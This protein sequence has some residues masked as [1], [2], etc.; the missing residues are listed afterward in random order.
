MDVRVLVTGALVMG[1]AGCAATATPAPPPTTVA[2]PAASNTVTATGSL[3]GVGRGGAVAVVLFSESD[4]ARMRTGQSVRLTVD[5]LPGVALRGTVTAIA[6]DAVNVSGVTEY[7]VTITVAGGD[8]RLR[9]GQTVQAT[10][11]VT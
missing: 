4:V 7:Y 8:S 1:L 3:S 2:H 10:V 5:A 11:T 6:P 9:A